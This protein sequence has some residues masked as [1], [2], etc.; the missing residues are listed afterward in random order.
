MPMLLEEGEDSWSCAAASATWHRLRETLRYVTWDPGRPL[1]TSMAKFGQ[2]LP[3]WLDG[4]G[5]RAADESPCAAGEAFFTLLD[6]LLSSL[7][8]I[9][10]DASLSVNSLADALVL[11]RLRIPSISAAMFSTWPIFGLMALAQQKLLRL[12]GGAWEA[13]GLGNGPEQ[14]ALEASMP[15]GE[16][17]RPFVGIC[18]AGQELHRILSDWLEELPPPGGSLPALPASAR[19]VAWRFGRNAAGCSILERGV[20]RLVA[21]GLIPTGAWYTSLVDHNVSAWR[22]DLRRLR[23]MLDWSLHLVTWNR[24]LLT[25]WPLPAILH[26]L[27]EAYLK[28]A[29]CSA[30]V[31]GGYALRSRAEGSPGVWLCVGRMEDLAAERWRMHGEFSDCTAIARLLRGG[32]PDGCLF[33]DIGANLGS[34]SLQM[35]REGFAVLALEPSPATAALLR[36]SVLRNGLESRI[37]VVQAAAGRGGVGRLR[38]PEKHSA[39]CTVQAA[40]KVDDGQLVSTVALDALLQ[41]RPRLCALKIDVEGSEEEALMGAWQSLHLRPRLFLEIHAQQ[42]RERGTSSGSIFDRLL[43]DLGYRDVKLLS[44]HESNCLS[45][46]GSRSRLT[47]RGDG[48]HA[49]YRWRGANLL[50]A[51]L[52]TERD[53]CRCARACFLQIRPGEPGCRCWDFDAESGHC[54]MYRSCEAVNATALAPRDRSWA[55]ELSGNFVFS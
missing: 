52:Y 49:E 38:C 28:E 6:F 11:L 30:A 29:V 35:A 2:L 19:R 36:A 5:R 34:C 46:S 47:P 4:E 23:T 39:A 27:Q 8:Q 41:K 14:R 18:E 10:D 17:L 25:G 51:G 20:A 33:A 42:L 44:D 37:E 53:A 22:K 43:M 40:D 45:A 15:F 1:R 31:E 26:R 12:G 21:S 24:L 16:A 3:L 50:P 7:Q 48:V 9:R 54:Q 55:G 32:S 13:P